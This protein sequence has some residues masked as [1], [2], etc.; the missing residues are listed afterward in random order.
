MN[1]LGPASALR[2]TVEANLPLGTDSLFPGQL[3]PELWDAAVTYGIDPVGMVAQSGKETGWGAFPGRV[4]PWFRNTAGIKVRFDREAM[5]LVP[6]IDP[7]HPLVHQQF[8]SWEVGAVAHAQ[9]LRAYCN[10]PVTD[11]IVDPRYELVIGRHDVVRWSDL[12]GK[13][14]GPSYG[15]E[16]EIVMQRLRGEL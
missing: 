3:V 9:H 14:A 4:K 16:I 5:A 8:P 10:L 15:T 11:L 1:I 12:D 7:D 13:W 6:T 2:A